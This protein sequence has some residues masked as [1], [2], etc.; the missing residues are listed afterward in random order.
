MKRRIL[1]LF[2]LGFTALAA[3]MVAAAS[4]SVTVPYV[5]PHH[6]VWYGG[7]SERSGYTYNWTNNSMLWQA[8]NG[9]TPQGCTSFVDTGNALDKPL[10]CSNTQIE[11]DGRTDTSY[12]AAYCKADNGNTKVI[13]METSNSDGCTAEHP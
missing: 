1:A 5:D 3:G 2:A 10:A 7:S 12:A 8:P 13:L 6:M 4:A 11:L 9:G